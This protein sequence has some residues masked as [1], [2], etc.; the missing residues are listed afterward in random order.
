M[1]NINNKTLSNRIWFGIKSGWQF[2]KLI[3]IVLIPVIF[4]IWFK[5]DI[6]LIFLSAIKFQHIILFY[7]VLVTGIILYNLLSLLLF[8]LFSKNKIQ[9]SNYTPTFLIGWFNEMKRLS[10]FEDK[11]WFIDD[12][13]RDIFLY[14]ILLL[15]LF[16]VFIFN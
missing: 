15:I 12:Y 11:R 5:F 14:S 3:L 2:L 1:K 13:L 7:I 4:L 16:Y 6:I 9:M 10:K 8:I